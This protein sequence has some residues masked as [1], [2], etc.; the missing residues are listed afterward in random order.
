MRKNRWQTL[1]WQHKSIAGALGA[2]QIGLLI[3]ALID[4]HRRP[5]VLIRGKKAWWTLASFVNFIGP[6]SYFIAGRK[7][8]GEEIGQI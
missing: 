3:A 7:D 1:S 5:R 4:I 2:V 8:P 6:I